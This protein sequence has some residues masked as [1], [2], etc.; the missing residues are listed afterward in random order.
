MLWLD[1][2]P[3][4]AVRDLLGVVRSIYA[5]AKS[6]NVAPLELSRIAAIGADLSEAMGLAAGTRPGTLG[7]AAAWRRA[8]EAT[9]RVGDLVDSLTPADALVAAARERGA[10]ARCMVRRKTPER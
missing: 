4:E 1:P 8:E 7:Q 9:R 6:A 2:F 10:G 5:A 3:F